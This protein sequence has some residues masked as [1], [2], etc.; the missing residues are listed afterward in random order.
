MGHY[1]N[2]ATRSVTAPRIQALHK[3]NPT[4]NVMQIHMATMQAEAEYK[5]KRGSEVGWT[6]SRRR[7]TRVKH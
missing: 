2:S 5:K 1:E 3:R 7:R 6:L 4:P